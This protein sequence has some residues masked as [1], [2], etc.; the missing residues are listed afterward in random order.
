MLSD[1]I[2]ECMSAVQLVLIKFVEQYLTISVRHFGINSLMYSK[3]TNQYLLNF[4][5]LLLRSLFK[6]QNG[7]F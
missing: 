3:A 6:N 7:L 1:N 4:T 5:D 2:S